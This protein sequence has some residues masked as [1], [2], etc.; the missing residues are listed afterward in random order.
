MNRRY[1][2]SEHDVVLSPQQVQ[3][4]FL[5]TPIQADQHT[6]KNSPSKPSLFIPHGNELIL[7]PIQSTRAHFYDAYSKGKWNLSKVPCPPFIENVGYMKP[8]ESYNEITRSESVSN[9][10]NLPHWKKIQYFTKIISKLKKTFK[11]N[12]V[13]ISLIDKDKCYYK[14]ETTLDL[15]CVPRCVAIDSHA[16]LSSGSFVLLD[17]SKDWRT[18]KNPLVTESPFIKFYC[19]APLLATNNDVIGIIAIFDSKPKLSFSEENCRALMSVSSDLMDFLNSSLEDDSSIAKIKTREIMDSLLLYGN[20]D[21][22]AAL[23]E[24][25]KEIGR[26]TSGKSSLIFEKDGSGGPYNANQITRFIRFNKQGEQNDLTKNR[27]ERNRKL[28]SFESQQANYEEQDLKLTLMPKHNQL[29]K[30]KELWKSLFALG[31]LNKAASSLC[32]TLATF[33]KFDFVF[34]LEIRIA[35][36]CCIPKEYFPANENKIDLGSFKYA[37]KITKSKYPKDE[38]M[39]RMTGMYKH[40]SPDHLKHSSNAI[41][42][43]SPTNSFFEKS[44][45]YK[46]FLSEFGLEYINPRVNTIYNYG[47]IMPFF[48]HDSKLLKHNSSSTRN[49]KNIDLYL[50]SGGFLIGLFSELVKEEVDSELISAIFDH[51]VTFRK[52][53]IST[54]Q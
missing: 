40:K 28:K 16:I 48:R 18:R 34:V 26:P 20:S 35:E 54:T 51:S 19:G 32:T 44:I 46:A 21:K 43:N 24:L 11:I 52:I 37:N 29:I 13:S 30:Q 53:Y 1:Y 33:Y 27:N 22:R 7:K 5:P 42:T 39:T 25:R 2:K 31:S 10:M 49:C 9:Y 41:L 15:N 38:F 4:V 8:P 36:Q 17:A 47:I 45:H 50:R 12:G 14:F 3:S 23:K 6:R